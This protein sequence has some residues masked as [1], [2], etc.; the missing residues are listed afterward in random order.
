[1]YWILVYNLACPAQTKTGMS[2]KL[3]VSNIG[4]ES[5]ANWAQ[6]LRRNNSKIKRRRCSYLYLEYG[7]ASYSLH[8]TVCEFTVSEVLPIQ[9]RRQHQ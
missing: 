7:A 8:L 6:K 3:L 4:D 9:Y 2:C 1:M 5:S